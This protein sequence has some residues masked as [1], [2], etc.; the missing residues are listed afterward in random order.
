MATPEIRAVTPGD[1]PAIHQL[2]LDFGRHWG[3]EEW[4]SGSPDALAQAL[5]GPDHKG[6]GHVAVIDGAVVG[7]ALWF[8][9]FNFW[10]AQPVLF[11]ED[12]YVDETARGSGAGEALMRALAGEAVARECAWMEW[13]VAVDNVAGQRF[14]A[15]HGASAK[16][17]YDL[18]RL[19]DDEL[20]SLAAGG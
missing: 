7:V 9:A 4:V 15:R 3:H 12:L 20:R 2:L 5:F 10:M 6:H 19:E 8:L 13:I 14:Y 18:W 16:V 17:E 1:V 11:L